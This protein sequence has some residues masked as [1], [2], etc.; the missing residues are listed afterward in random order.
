MRFHVM[1]FLSFPTEMASLPEGCSAS[2][3][4]PPVC[5]LRVFST[6]K[7]FVRKM[8]KTRIRW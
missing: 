6:W 3:V 8:L 7:F 4:T 2:E 5:L 1:S